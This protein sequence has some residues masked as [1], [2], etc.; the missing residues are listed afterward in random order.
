[1]F[2]IYYDFI[3]FV[4]F[5][6][7]TTS[8]CYAP[9]FLFFVLLSSP[10]SPGRVSKGVTEISVIFTLLRPSGT[11]GAAFSGLPPQVAGRAGSECRP[12]QR[13]ASQ[14]FGSGREG[15]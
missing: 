15:D 9:T 1:M 12:D 6:Y 13:H 14:C 7:A 10:P 3:S 5:I 11:A 2:L 4:I 8:A